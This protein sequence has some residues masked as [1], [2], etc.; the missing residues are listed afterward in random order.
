MSEDIAT[1]AFTAT[2]LLAI[3]PTIKADAEADMRT[4]LAET[5]ALAAMGMLLSLY[6]GL[7]PGEV[8]ALRVG[9]VVPITNP[10][11]QVRSERERD[12][13]VTRAFIR[14]TGNW[15]NEHEFALSLYPLA[16]RQRSDYATLL[17]H[18][19]LRPWDPPRA[20]RPDAIARRFKAMCAAA[21]LGTRYTSISLRH[22][23]AIALLGAGVS[24]DA[25]E[26]HLYGY[27]HAPAMM[28]AYGDAIDRYGTR[29][30]AELGDALGEWFDGLA[31]D[32]GQYE[33]W[34]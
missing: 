33:A 23:H 29:E 4:S 5:R 28:R 21:G 18:A 19:P 9:D 15:I 22:T 34:C 14:G 24:I 12:A 20:I 8:C 25:L 17:R 30:A 11:I 32:I 2:D 3:L 7:T 26:R 6:A 13:T 31:Q 16:G 1:R 27:G 10:V